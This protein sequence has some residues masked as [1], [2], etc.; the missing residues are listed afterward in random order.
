[1]LEK[2]V[3]QKCGLDCKSIVD[4]KHGYLFFCCEN[5]YI[6]DVSWQIKDDSGMLNE[7]GHCLYYYKLNQDL[8]NVLRSFSLEEDELA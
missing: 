4:F 8:E 7:G 6:E 3:C 2:I 5:L 1:M